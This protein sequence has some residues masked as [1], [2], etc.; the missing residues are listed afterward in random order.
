MKR[1][2][3]F[4]NGRIAQNALMSQQGVF[5]IQKY[6]LLN[7]GFLFDLVSTTGLF[8]AVDHRRLRGQSN[9]PVTLRRSSDATSTTTSWI[10]E[11]FNSAAASSFVGSANGTSQV[12]VD[13]SG[14]FRHFNQIGPGQGPHLITAGVIQTLNSKQVSKGISSSSLGLLYNPG[15]NVLVGSTLTI[16]I[17]FTV[18]ST[19]DSGRILTAIQ[20]SDAP[21]ASLGFTLYQGAANSVVFYY[22]PG[23]SIAIG[24]VSAGPHVVSIRWN[25]S[26][27]SVRIDGEAWVTQNNA[28][29]YSVG[30]ISLFCHPAGS[31]YTNNSI[32][33]T[34]MWNKVLSDAELSVIERNL[35]IYYQINVA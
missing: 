17:V 2:I 6:H 3:D 8:L 31:A 18:S 32:A 10:G 29:T 25:G 16:N 21:E 9:W 28:T 22:S 34:Y 20:T 1:G 24:G 4:N 15:S 14:N 5:N 27:V 19:L 13:Q 33:A 26:S 30:K 35:G 23:T 7:Q 11:H 12:W